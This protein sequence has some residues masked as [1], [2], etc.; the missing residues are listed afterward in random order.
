MLHDEPFDFEYQGMYL[1]NEVM[2]AG[3]TLETTCTFKQPMTFGTD[4]DMEMCY[5]F[6]M[7][8]PLGALA[9]LDPWSVIAHGGSS[10]ITTTV[11]PF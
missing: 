5:L 10:C 7:A 2:K 8:Y 9:Q 3:D 1:K 11:P 6:T 4:T